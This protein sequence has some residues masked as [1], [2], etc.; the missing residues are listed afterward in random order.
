MKP[1]NYPIIIL[2]FLTILSCSKEDMSPAGNSDKYFPKVKAIIKTNCTITC[3]S[4]STGHYQGLPVILDNDTD[5]AIRAA[6]IEAAVAGPF[7]FMNK[8]MPLGGHLSA[9]DIDIIKKW[10]EKGGKVTD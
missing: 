4:P 3:H 7:T 2:S 8:Q 9:S 1:K 5:I 10:V 6:N